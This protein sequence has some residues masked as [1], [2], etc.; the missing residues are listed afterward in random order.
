MRRNEID[1][2]RNICVLLLFV[3]HTASIFTYYEPW[4]IWADS[5]SWLATIIFILCIPWHMPVL[6]FLAGASTRFSLS[7]RSGKK[8]IIERVKKLLIPFILGMLILVPPQGYFARVSRGRPVGNYFQQYKYFWTTVSDIPYDGGFGPAHLWFILYLFIISII[9]L[10]IIRSFKKE[11]VKKFLL[12][13]KDKL[14]NKYS[15]VFSVLVLFIAD[16]TPLAIAQKNILIFLIVFLM[17]YIVYS[18]NDYLVY[19]DK[20][21]RKSLIITIIFLIFYIGVILPYY[22]LD[23][24]DGKGLKI[25]LSIMRNGAMI[26]TIVAIIGY[27]RKYLTSAG[28]FLNYLNKACFPVYILH[29][30]VIVIVAYYLLNYYALPM[31]LSI[32]IILVSS[33]PIT[34]GIYEIFRRIK[35]T[36]Y[37]IGVK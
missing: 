21:K 20:K 19:I 35:I 9:G 27:G 13:L 29:Q 16:M 24:N 14:T 23:N 18:D 26:T 17:G 37:L 7:S 15:L 31:Y 36:K 1:W 4:Y 28:K 6:F 22:N 34:F 30:P 33:V 10:F 2:I 8:Y 12:R 5:K 25:L 3:F 11:G 32:L